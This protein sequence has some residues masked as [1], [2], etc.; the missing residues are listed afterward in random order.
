MKTVIPFNSL[1]MGFL[2]EP[3]DS[4]HKRLVRLIS[5]QFPLNGISL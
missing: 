3:E 5:F 1:L 4:K 2:F